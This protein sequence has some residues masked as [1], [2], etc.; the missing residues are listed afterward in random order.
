MERKI[1]KILKEWK[2]Y[3]LA[4]AKLKIKQANLNEKI[5]RTLQV[6]QFGFVNLDYP[7]SY[8]SG[9]ELPA[10]FADINGNKLSLNNIVLI[11]KGTNAIYRYKDVIKFNP[12]KDNI[13]CGITSDNKLAFIKKDELAKYSNNSKKIIMRIFEG[14]LNKYEDLYEFI[15]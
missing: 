11:E 14:K 4:L 2:N 5:I 13:L 6:N 3:E 10:V 9:V 1:A 12:K 8:P 7:S 15:F